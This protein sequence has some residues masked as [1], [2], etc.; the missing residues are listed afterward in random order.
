MSIDFSLEGAGFVEDDPTSYEPIVKW[1][2]AWW[3][4]ADPKIVRCVAHRMNGKQ[5]KHA[6]MNGTTVCQTHGGRAPQVVNRA[7]I[8]IAEATDKAAKGLLD[9][10]TDTTIP[11]GV[12]LSAIKDILD[13]GGL[14]AKQEITVSA[15][16]YE[17]VFDAIGGG[18]RAI[19]P[20]TNAEDEEEV[21]PE[22]E[23]GSLKARLVH[24]LMRDEYSDLEP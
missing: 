15:K 7:R 12:R 19:A 24:R 6:A 13:R 17:N 18:Q 20:P 23:P 21:D 8:R 16:P 3:K 5:C 14:G 2:E 4:Q 11:E 1:S 10:A 9:L 22:N